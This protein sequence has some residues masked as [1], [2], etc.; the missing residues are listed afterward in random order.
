MIF[1]CKNKHLSEYQPD[2]TARL[3]AVRRLRD[4]AVAMGKD[5]PD[6]AFEDLELLKENDPGVYAS[7]LKIESAL[8][9]IMYPTSILNVPA[10]SP[11]T[12]ES[13][14]MNMLILGIAS[15]VATVISSIAVNALKSL[16]GSTN[17]TVAMMMFGSSF[18][19]LGTTIFIL[20][21]IIGATKS[22]DFK[23]Y[24]PIGNYTRL[25][26]GAILGWMFLVL[27]AF[28]ETAAALQ[29][30]LD[31]KTPEVSGYAYLLLPFIAGYSSSLTLSLLDNF[32]EAIRLAF[33]LKD[34]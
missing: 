34:K 25:V 3:S 23:Y 19:L 33:G 10:V 2:F 18:G 15:F 11:E 16:E 7:L 27:F 21:N 20:F 5:I 24:D 13:F 8:T 30:D 28:E 31:T 32:I 26:S 4:F 29:M 22:A 17:H 1:L 9:K 12:V 14:R 6:Q